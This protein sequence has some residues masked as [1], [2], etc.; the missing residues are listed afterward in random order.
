MEGL[1]RFGGPMVAPGTY[2]AE[3][4]QIADGKETSLAEPVEFE[5]ESISQ[6]T[7]KGQNRKTVIAFIKEAG[8]M[9]NKI[10]A[11]RTVLGERQEQLTE[12][13]GAI[14]K[15]PQGTAELIAKATKLKKRLSDYKLQIS[16]DDLKAEKWILSEPS[17]ESRIR[18]ALMSG[19]SG[20]HGITKTAKQQYRI[21]VE[22]FESI[23]KELFRLLDKEIEAFEDEVDKA[24]IPW[25]SGRDLPK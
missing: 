5:V 20:T 6:P 4:F 13:V 24:G 10:S 15:H 23:E 14:Q 18:G 9:A 19:M 12:L 22:Q 1:T 11:A 8:L 3:P 2:I 16:G 21:G 17:I 7:I 25:T